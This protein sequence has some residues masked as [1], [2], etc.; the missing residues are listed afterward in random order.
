MMRLCTGD[1]QRFI[2]KC[3]PADCQDNIGAAERRWAAIYAANSTSSMYKIILKHIPKGFDILEMGCSAGNLQH[4][5]MLMGVDMS[6]PALT[7]AKRKSPNVR[8]VLADISQSRFSTHDVVVALNM[9]DVVEPYTLLKSMISHAT[10]Y[11]VLSDPYDYSRG[12]STVKTPMDSITIREHIQHLGFQI[13]D[14]TAQPSFVPWEIRINSRT[15]V[16]YLVDIIVA[17]RV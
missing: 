6:F 15:S 7:Y 17:K 4:D 2:A 3:M 16:R 13:S 14:N 12:E 10:R 9:L 11:I 1:T 5:N 8:Y